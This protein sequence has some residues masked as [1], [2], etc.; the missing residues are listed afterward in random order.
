MTD[1]SL[2]FA[3]VIEVAVVVL[4]FYIFFKNK[5]KKEL[6]REL[7]IKIIQGKEDDKEFREKEL[8]EQLNM[9]S[10]DPA[11]LDGV[12]SEIQSNELK[13]YQ[14]VIKVFL[15]KEVSH[16]KLL[17]KYVNS[18]SS[19]YWQILNEHCTKFVSANE[20]D[21]KKLK[22][23]LKVA[24]QEEKHLS[25]RLGIALKTLDEVSDEYTNMF[26]KEAGLDDLMESKARMIG[27]FNQG[28]KELSG[29][30]K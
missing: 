28:S 25:E 15:Q 21:L 12:V 17:E 16:L 8:K 30:G 6:E 10:I 1:Q 19:P 3:L 11:G 9:P 26:D 18:L 29:K 23:K 20:A 5:S 13:F 2:V 14:Y 24:Q 7:I 22:G 27:F 4:V